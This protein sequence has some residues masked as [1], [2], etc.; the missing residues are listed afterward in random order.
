MINSIWACLRLLVLLIGNHSWKRP[1]P[2]LFHCSSHRNNTLTMES[3]GVGILPY[4]FFSSVSFSMSAHAEMVESCSV[5]QASCCDAEPPDWFMSHQWLLVNHSGQTFKS[6]KQRR[7]LIPAKMGINSSSILTK[8]SSER[9]PAARNTKK[10]PKWHAQTK[11]E[12]SIWK[13]GEV[14]CP[15]LLPQA[16]K[17]IS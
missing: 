12:S 3:L 15:Q 14:C 16:E 1:P 13:G 8:L 10:M 11:K 5:T 9:H 4:Q 2:L 17:I 7:I 6:A